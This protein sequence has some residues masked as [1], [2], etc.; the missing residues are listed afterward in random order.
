MKKLL[1]VNLVVAG[2]L[3]T[4]FWTFTFFTHGAFISPVGLRIGILCGF[5]ALMPLLLSVLILFVVNIYGVFKFWSKYKLVTLLPFLI[6]GIAVMSLRAWD[7]EAMSI[8]RFEKY[9]PDYEAFAATAEKGHKHGDWDT[10]ALP[11]EYRHL[12]YLAVVYDDEPNTL[13]VTI[14]VGNFGVFGHTAFLY[15]S[16]GE[17]TRGSK[18]SREWPER[19]RVNERWFRVSD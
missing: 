19:Q 13:C 14:D 17:I 9:L 15:S 1:I 8:R 18:T 12:G 5:F 4:C 16:N 7:V 3:I 11:K 10:I 6:L 2:L